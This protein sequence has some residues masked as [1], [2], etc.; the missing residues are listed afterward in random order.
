MLNDFKWLYINNLPSHI[1]R[2]LEFG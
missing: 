2:N 1:K